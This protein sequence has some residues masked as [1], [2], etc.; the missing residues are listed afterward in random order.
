MITYIINGHHD[1]QIT[2]HNKDYL[3]VITLM[4]CKI[5]FSNWYKKSQKE[6]RSIDR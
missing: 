6:E 2:Y 1:Q 3:V 4:F 5:M